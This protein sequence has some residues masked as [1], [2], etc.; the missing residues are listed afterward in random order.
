MILTKLM[1]FS[2][3]KYYLSKL[4]IA[5]SILTINALAIAPSQASSSVNV[6]LEFDSLPSQQGWTY[7][8]FGGNQPENTVFS[9]NNNVL[10]QNTVG[11]GDN[12][13]YYTLANIVDE[14]EEFTLSWRSRVIE[15]EFVGTPGNHFGLTIGVI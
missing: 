9:V 6:T 1:K 11:L 12:V 5:S 14:T 8:T 3:G 13:I 15:E 7:E 10:T 4:A 2:E